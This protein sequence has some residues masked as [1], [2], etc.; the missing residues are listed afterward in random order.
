MHEN[1]VGVAELDHNVII[2]KYHEIVNQSMIFLYNIYVLVVKL[3]ANIM[4]IGPT[5]N[6]LIIYQTTTNH[7]L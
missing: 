4:N 6:R 7:R 3:W 2:I 1:Y 5:S